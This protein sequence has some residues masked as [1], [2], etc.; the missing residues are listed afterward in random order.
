MARPKKADGQNARTRILEAFGS[1]AR[2]LPVPAITVGAVCSK[3]GCN[4]TT[5]YYHYDTFDD[6]L[7]AYLESMDVTGVS[8]GFIDR[9]VGGGGVA[10]DETERQK[11]SE[12]FDLMCGL[13]ALNPDGPMHAK[14]IGLMREHAMTALN[15]CG[16]PCGSAPDPFVEMLSEFTAG[17]F[18]ALI[19]YRGRN[20]ESLDFEQMASG[21]YEDIIPAIVR[22]SRRGGDESQRRDA[23]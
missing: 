16:G 17:G 18:L 22:S 10:L 9:L 23:S 21:F 12:G 2:G 19:A 8:K 11:V 7:D 3:A 6:M 15:A 4:K 20:A 14:L 1:L 13:A 5:F